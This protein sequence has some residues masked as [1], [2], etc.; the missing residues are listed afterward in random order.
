MDFEEFYAKHSPRWEDLPVLPY[1]WTFA[2]MNVI[3]IKAKLPSYWCSLIAVKHMPEKQ[4]W[5][6]S[7]SLEGA[8]WDILSQIEW[9]ER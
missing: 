4:I 9:E 2:A 8:V 5:A 1:G 7:R 3:P 6:A